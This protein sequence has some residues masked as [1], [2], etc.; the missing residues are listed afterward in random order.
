MSLPVPRHGAESA[1]RGRRLFA[2]V[3]SIS[4]AAPSYYLFQQGG[5]RM[6][7]TVDRKRR[8]APD[9]RCRRGRGTGCSRRNGPDRRRPR[10]PGLGMLGG[11]PG[12]DGLL[13]TCLR[14]D[15]TGAEP[16]PPTGE[17]VATSCRSFVDTGSCATVSSPTPLS[18]R[19]SSRAAAALPR[20]VCGKSPGAVPPQSRYTACEWIPGARFGCARMAKKLRQADTVW[21]ADPTQSSSNRPSDPMARL[22]IVGVGDASVGLDSLRRLVGSLPTG[23]GL[24]IV[25]VRHADPA[26]APFPASM[27]QQHTPCAAGWSTR[28]REWTCRRITF[29]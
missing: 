22:V 13:A 20:F 28:E 12:V 11:I 8:E 10:R 5:Q 6:A 15:S 2:A 25:L 21:R 23:I 16:A 29:T 26:Q 18:G 27:I 19:Q 3:P 1:R 24:A 4:G 14:N 17:R 9:Q 7:I